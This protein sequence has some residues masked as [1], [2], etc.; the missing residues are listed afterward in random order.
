MLIEKAY[1]KAFKGYWNIGTGGF[2]ED[3]LKDLTGAPTEYEYLDEKTNTEQVW[4]KLKY[5][6]E[7]K[8]IICAGSKGQGEAKTDT[9]IIEGHAY[10]VIAVHEI[11][12]KKILE[13][14]NPWGQGEWKGAFSDDDDEN[15]TPELREKYGV[16]KN[17][18]KEDGRFFI[19]YE[20]FLVWFNQYS[21]CYYEDN[22][23]LQSFNDTVEADEINCYKFNVTKPGDY[24]ISLS[25]PDTRSFP[26]DQKVDKDGK[27][28]DIDKEYSCNG[29]L[30]CKKEANGS[31][32]YL[33]GKQGE[34]R[35]IWIKAKMA[36]EIYVFVKT[37]WKHPEVTT[38]F[39]LSLYG[40]EAV[41]F[42]RVFDTPDL[43]L[44][45]IISFALVNKAL[46]ESGQ[47]WK[48]L[49]KVF[50]WS[51]VFS[52]FE[53]SNIG[54]GF[55]AFRNGS[56]KTLRISLEM[57]KRR[58]VKF[59]TPEP[60]GDH[61]EKIEILIPAGSTGIAIWD[62]YSDSSAINFKTQFRTA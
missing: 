57:T 55:Y 32:T 28:I 47:E 54:Y 8:Y 30:V 34:A 46:L 39:G 24:Y 33:G 18:S 48:P 23:T 4:K 42:T 7:Q 41:N 17:A 15:W 40:P 62:I 25:Q 19:P 44:L 3:A 6:D 58:N 2:A 21:I 51:K 52:N 14:R 38:T 37:E 35:D 11:S 36:G 20:D 29:I 27:V 49:G 13:C 59:L 45:R 12:G 1:A 9:G 50:T 43:P 56:E 5:C 16:E 22:Y 31:F 60:F 61:G 53:H 10:T 26:W